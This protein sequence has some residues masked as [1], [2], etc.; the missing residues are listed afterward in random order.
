[1]NVRPNTIYGRPGLRLIA[2]VPLVMLLTGQS[3]PQSWP[4]QAKQQMGEAAPVD[5]ARLPVARSIAAGPTPRRI[6]VD[7]TPRLE[8]EAPGQWR[9]RGWQM[10]SSPTGA[11]MPAGGWM[12]AVVPGTALTT[13]IANGR[14]ADPSYGL[15]NLKIPETLARQDYWYRTSLTLPASAR[16]RY[17][18]LVFEG[19]NYAAEVRLDGQPLGTIRG[20]FLR[21][22]FALPAT[23][24]DGRAHRLEVR[25]SPPPRPG[26]PHEQSLANGPGN[27]GGQMT[28]DGPTFVAAEGW[29]WI[30]GVR[31]RNA[32]LWQDVKLA[33]TGPV[34]IGD[35]DVRTILPRADNKVADVTIEVPLVNQSDQ[36]Q[37][38][39]V[40]AAFDAVALTKTVTAAPGASIVTLSPAEFPALH[41]ANPRL[42]WPNG[43]GAPELHALRVTTATAGGA[44]DERHIRFGMREISYD[45][46]V[47]RTAAAPQRVLYR[48]T[49]GAG[50]QLIAVDHA[51]IRPVEGGWAPTMLERGPAG[52][53]AD[54]PPTP[55]APHMVIRVNHVPIAVRGGNWGMDDWLKRVD[56]ARLEPY[57]RLHR[58]ANLNTIRNWVGQSTEENFF[59]LAD[60]YGLM[61]LNDFWISTQDWNGEPDD[62]KLF[63]ANA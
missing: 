11:A 42:W 60:K 28:L 22:R 27:N 16:G 21:G 34:R 23:A 15:N 33:V 46:T 17:A 24:A 43:Y 6:A 56:T 40:R 54:Q 4:L 55:L 29:D 14:Y 36:P 57:F 35:L 51:N 13:L 31:D 58:D 30:P 39:T 61:V 1:M 25:I 5:P 9:V 44:S 2:L 48:P 8:P 19:I 10:A 38:V 53:V 62:A 47:N 63:L 59:A 20:A 41:V 26:F 49:L 12:A 50:A 52:A 3:A 18:A 7:A 37:S 32:G 45:L